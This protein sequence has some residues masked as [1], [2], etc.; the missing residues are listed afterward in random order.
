MRESSRIRVTIIRINSF[1]YNDAN[2]IQI[3][4]EALTLSGYN[5][6]HENAVSVNRK[7]KMMC[8]WDM[9]DKRVYTIVL[10]FFVIFDVPPPL[11]GVI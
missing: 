4:S 7:C 10:T 1:R 9:N 3:Y 6:N 11:N 5:I 8:N 2:I